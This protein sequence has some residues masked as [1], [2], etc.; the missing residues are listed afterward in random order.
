MDLDDRNN[1]SICSSGNPLDLLNLSDL[2]NTITKLLESTSFKYEEKLTFLERLAEEG[3]IDALMR[4]AK[5]AEE[6]HS[7]SCTSRR[8]RSSS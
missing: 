1:H 5:E 3:N 2:K 8:G 6:E 4:E 7:V